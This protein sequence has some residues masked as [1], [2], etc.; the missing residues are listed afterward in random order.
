MSKVIREDE[1][2]AELERL[3]K[4]NDQGQSRAE[5][6]K[7]TG[8]GERQV[9]VLLQRA[10]E[11]GWLV[12]GWRT[13]IKINGYPNTIPVYRIVRPATIAHRSVK[14]GGKRKESR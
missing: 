7:A 12:L 8:K 2:L 4:K 9:L 5:I 1:W 3:S 14:A 13:A 10:K 11:L 6:A